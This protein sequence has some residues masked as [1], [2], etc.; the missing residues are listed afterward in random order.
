[1][2]E[3]DHPWKESLDVFFESFLRIFVYHYRLL[4]P[5]NRNENDACLLFG[6]LGSQ[7]KGADLRTNQRGQASLIW[8]N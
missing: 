4:D 1:M 8:V 7:S 2:A 6:K 5:H 3:F